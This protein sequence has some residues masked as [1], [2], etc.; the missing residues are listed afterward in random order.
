MTICRYD[1]SVSSY[2]E[3]V[4][5]KRVVEKRNSNNFLQQKY[6]LFCI[7][8]FYFKVIISKIK[9]GLVGVI[10]YDYL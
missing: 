8:N 10:L 9:L 6:I 2:F 7:K 3:M 1:I 5:H 4:Q